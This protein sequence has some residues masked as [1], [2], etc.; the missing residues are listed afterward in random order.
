ML[1]GVDM[2]KVKICKDESTL[3]I[4][5]FILVEESL[6]LQLALNKNSDWRQNG[7]GGVD[8]DWPSTDMTLTGKGPYII[9]TFLSFMEMSFYKRKLRTALL[10]RPAPCKDTDHSKGEGLLQC[11]KSSGEGRGWS[12]V[13][14]SDNDVAEFPAKCKDLL[15]LCRFYQ[16][17]GAAVEV[18]N[19]MKAFVEYKISLGSPDVLHVVANFEKDADFLGD[20]P[21]DWGNKICTNLSTFIEFM[22]NS[23]PPSS[24]SRG[25]TAGASD[26]QAGDSSFDQAQAEGPVSER[27]KILVYQL[28]KQT[29]IGIMV[30]GNKINPCR[31]DVGDLE[32]ASEEHSEQGEE[33]M[34]P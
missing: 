29:L 14:S 17:S 33:E 28:R 21:F 11:I 7:T 19:L 23:S 3:L 26:V 25:K 13:P 15:E 32:F 4:P 10:P 2:V 20:P 27:A 6:V 18:Y 22:E 9:A 1:P 24:L 8:G 16:A 30:Y 12:F 5:L 34:L 31:Y